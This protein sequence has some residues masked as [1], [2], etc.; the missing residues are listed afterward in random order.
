[1]KIEQ[2]ERL[3]EQISRTALTAG[4]EILKVY[5]TDF[6]VENKADESPLTLADQKAHEAIVAQ[7][8]TSS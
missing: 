4:M 5:D 7:L 6:E 2:K 3:L 8:K 1:M